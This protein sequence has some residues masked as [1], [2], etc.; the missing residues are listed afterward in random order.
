MGILCNQSTV[1]QSYARLSADTLLS[2][3]LDGKTQNQNELLN[4][5]I[6]N[7]LLQKRVIRVVNKD[8]FDA[9]TEPIFNELKIL[10]VEKI[11]KY[12]LGKFMYLYQN[13]LLPK[14]FDGFF[15]LFGQ[16]HNYHTR[17]ASL[18]LLPF[19]RTNIRKFS[20]IYQA[21]NFF[22]TLCQDIR[23]ASTVTSFQNKLRKYLFSI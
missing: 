11:Y 22:N 8:K 5:M 16:V 12:H 21:P 15:T 10:S 20:V 13:N 19:C 7:R 18:Y 1:K 17:N 3:C 14:V 6:W 2:K 23:Q 4:E 9:H